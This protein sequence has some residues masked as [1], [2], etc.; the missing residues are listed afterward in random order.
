METM[1]FDI[2]IAFDKNVG[3]YYGP[4]VWKRVT[5][6]ERVHATSRERAMQIAEARTGACAIRCVCL[7]ER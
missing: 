1:P 5:R 4:P 3:R 6:V 7:W 2:T